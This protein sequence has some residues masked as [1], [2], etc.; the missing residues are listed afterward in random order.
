MQH[1]FPSKLWCSWTLPHC[2]CTLEWLQWV[3]LP[4]NQAHIHLMQTLWDSII[5]WYS[6]GMLSSPVEE[7]SLLFYS[8]PRQM[9]SSRTHDPQSQSRTVSTLKLT[10]QPWC[11]SFSPSS[12]QQM[13]SWF[14]AA[15][16]GNSASTKISFFLA[17]SS[18]ILLWLSPFTSSLKS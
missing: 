6:G 15:T 1:F 16:H 3:V 8:I 13:S 2:C 18:S 10:Q 4:I 7:P 9:S 17:S 12:T 11:S 5:I 14:I